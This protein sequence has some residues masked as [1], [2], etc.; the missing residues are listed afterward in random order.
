MHYRKALVATKSL[1]PS[2][3][4]LGKRRNHERIPK[5][6]E[7]WKIAHTRNGNGECWMKKYTVLHL[8]SASS[9]KATQNPLEAISTDPPKEG[10]HSEAIQRALFII[11][12][13]ESSTWYSPW[14][15]RCK[16]DQL[17]KRQRAF[18]PKCGKTED[19][20]KNFGAAEYQKQ[21]GVTEPVKEDED[22]CGPRWEKNSETTNRS[23]TR[24]SMYWVYVVHCQNEKGREDPAMASGLNFGL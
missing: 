20:H 7:S 1:T 12:I 3:S 9:I 24:N 4:K 8:V 6:M 10:G 14:C 5:S 2:I 19:A 23:A 21:D 17:R 18:Q 22:S 13:I 15:E 16:P 11:A